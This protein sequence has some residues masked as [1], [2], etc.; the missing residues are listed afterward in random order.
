MSYAIILAGCASSFYADSCRRF[1][2]WL[3]RSPFR[4]QFAI[5]YLFCYSGEARG[6]RFLGCGSCMEPTPGPGGALPYLASNLIKNSLINLHLSLEVS[7]ATILAGFA[8]LFYADSCRRFFFRLLEVRFV[9]VFREVVRD[10]IS[11][12]AR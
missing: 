11:G 8:S 2:F 3:I 12:T 7:Y 10:G 1:D 9:T 5:L 4:D 6:L